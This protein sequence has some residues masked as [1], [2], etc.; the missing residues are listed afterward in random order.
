MKDMK[1][2]LGSYKVA[3]PEALLAL[4]PDKP[5]K[6]RMALIPNAQDYYAERARDFKVAESVKY[7]KKL[8]FRPE[9]VDLR[10]YKQR[11]LAKT[12]QDYDCIWVLGGNTFCL[13]V[14]MQ[15]SGLDKIIKKLVK[16][17]LVYGGE[18]AGAIVAG[19]TLRGIELADEPA[20][21][22]KKIFSGLGLVPQI[23]ISH[24]DNLQYAPLIKQIAK[25][26]V[27]NPNRVVLNDNQ[28]LIIN[29]HHHKIVTGA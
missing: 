17:G 10:F 22:D 12:L 16:E 21:A 27:D 18:S 4:L 26:Y 23:V 7:F 29:N 3:V 13:R 15:R 28:A 6:V 25:M 19:P 9:V 5:H 11:E 8:G 14:E 2:Y 20:Y 24:A 1:L